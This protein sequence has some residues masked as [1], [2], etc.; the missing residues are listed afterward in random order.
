M[1]RWAGAEGLFEEAFGWVV[2]GGPAPDFRR[3]CRDPSPPG[4]RHR[5]QPLGEKRHLGHPVGRRAVPCAS[6]FAFTF[7]GG[8]GFCGY[9]GLPVPEA[10]PGDCALAEG[11]AVLFRTALLSVFFVCLE[12]RTT[13]EDATPAGGVPAPPYPFWLSSG[14]SPSRGGGAP[15][16]SAT[17][18]SSPERPSPA[19]TPRLPPRAR[20]ICAERRANSDT[21]RW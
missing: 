14:A 4:C 9:R 6:A 20:E 11:W 16:Q 17:K 15:W 10:L 13:A 2:P 7:V 18:C 12:K 1:G 8:C 5:L 3:L 19:T 21:S